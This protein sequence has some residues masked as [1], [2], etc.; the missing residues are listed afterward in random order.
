[1]YF[2]DGCPSDLQPVMTIIGWVVFLIQLGIPIIL[3]VLGM[4]DLGKAVISSKEDEI[5][6]AKKSLGNRAIYAIAVFLVVWVVRLVMGWLPDLFNSDDVS[7]EN[8][9]AWES[10]WTCISKRG[11]C[12][13]SD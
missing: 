8:T 5:K 1:M 3:I 7:E 13:Y 2:L 11:K 9:R 12:T 10:C 6:K 4:L